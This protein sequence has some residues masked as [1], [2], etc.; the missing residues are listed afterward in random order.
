MGSQKFSFEILRKKKY[1][2]ITKNP[3]ICLT[4]EEQCVKDVKIHKFLVSAGKSEDFAQSQK[5]FARSHD[6]DF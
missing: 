6:H 1:K 2:N 5:N 3:L 4:N